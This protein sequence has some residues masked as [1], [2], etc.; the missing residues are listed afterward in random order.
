[1][2]LRTKNENDVVC[3]SSKEKECNNGEKEKNF[4]PKTI[5]NTNKT[6]FFVDNNVVAI[7]LQKQYFTFLG[8]C[9]ITQR[10]SFSKKYHTKIIKKRFHFFLGNI[11]PHLDK[12]FF[13]PLQPF[14]KLKPFAIHL[15]PF[16]I[17]LF[18]LKKIK[19]GT[20]NEILFK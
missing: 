4:G 8:A 16:F 12:A 1:M 13:F 17:F 5:K 15:V 9:I 7:P 3:E 11:T 19:I 6:L 2:K 18:F 20:K 14:C 10:S